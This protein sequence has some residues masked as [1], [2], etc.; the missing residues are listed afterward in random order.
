M[1]FLLFLGASSWIV[2]LKVCQC[3][4][5]RSVKLVCCQDDLKQP[6]L[7]VASCHPVSMCVTRNLTGRRA[8]SSTLQKVQS[9]QAP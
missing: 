1:K 4:A 8:V 3:L 9:I 2:Q 5:R 6:S 7:Y